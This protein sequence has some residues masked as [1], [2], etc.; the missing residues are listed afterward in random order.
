MRRSLSVT[1]LLDGKNN[2]L[3]ESL[4]SIYSIEI[5]T[6]LDQFHSVYSIYNSH[7]IGVPYNQI[8]DTG[9]FTHELL[10]IEMDRIGLAFPAGLKLLVLAKPNVSS[11]FSN[12]LLN[13]FINSFAH[14][15]MLPLFLQ[16][17]YTRK[18]FISD[19]VQDKLSYSF[20]NE[21]KN[22]YFIKPGVISGRSVDAFIGQFASAVS[23]SNDTMNYPVKLEILKSIDPSLYDVLDKTYKDWLE[24]KENSIYPSPHTVSYEFVENLDSWASQRNI[25]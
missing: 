25:L 20:L 7:T 9:G 15:K 3:W 5:V 6:T 1:E 13:H 10:H 2:A 21:L 22:S 18:Q 4:S 19:Y 16:M 11:F 24:V 23:C 17:G 8:S 14:I 12:D